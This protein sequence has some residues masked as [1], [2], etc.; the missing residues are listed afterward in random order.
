MKLFELQIDYFLPLWRRVLL[1]VLVMGWAVVEFVA[2]ASLWGT[3]FV[4]IGVYS[5]WQFFLDGWPSSDASDTSEISSERHSA[6][7]GSIPEDSA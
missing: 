1:V 6:S 7:G 4:S 2:G 3:V 5:I